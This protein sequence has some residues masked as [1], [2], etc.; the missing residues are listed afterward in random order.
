MGVNYSFPS[1]QFGL[2]GSPQ[3]KWRRFFPH[4]PAKLAPMDYV[5]PKG[6]AIEG[7]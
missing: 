2:I 5:R 6:G 7:D 4:P 3:T 1:W